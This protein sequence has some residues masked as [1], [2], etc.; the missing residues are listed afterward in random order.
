MTEKATVI[1]SILVIYSYNFKRFERVK[2]LKGTLKLGKK[3]STRLFALRVEVKAL[4]TTCSYLTYVVLSRALF[5]TIGSQTWSEGL[6][7]YVLP[8]NGS[9]YILFLTSFYLDLERCAYLYKVLKW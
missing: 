5:M 1:Y 3:V 8:K 4:I 6:R 9:A 2:S 7:L